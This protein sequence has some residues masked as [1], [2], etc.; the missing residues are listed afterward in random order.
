MS[1]KELEVKELICELCRQFFN[2]GWVTG[3]GG[4]ISIRHE[5]KIFMTPSGVQK[6]R[7]KADELFA[8][9]IKGAIT[10][11]P[12]QKPGGR[13]PKLSDCAPLFLHAYQ[14]RNAGAVLHSHA[15]CCNIVTTLFEGYSEFKISHQEM[16]KGIDGHGYFDQ[17]VVPI[18]ENTA[19]EHELADS[20]GETI[21]KYPK[22]P[23]VLVR[24]HGMYVWGNTWE[25]AKRHGE[26]LHYLFDIAIRMKQ[27]GLDFNSPP[28]PLLAVGNK[29]SLHQN[30]ETENK[31]QDSATDKFQFV[32][33]DIEGTTT[34]ITFVKDVLFPYSS[35]N[36][37]AY[38]TAHWSSPVTVGIVAALQEQVSSDLLDLA[39][40]D[41]PSADLTSVEAVVSYAQWCIQNDRKVTPLKKLQGLIWEAGYQTGALQGQVYPDVAPALSKWCNGGA[42]VAIYSSGSKQA[43]QLLFAHSNS[44]DLREYL[45]AYFDTSIGQ[46]AQSDSY[47]EILLTLGISNARECLFVTDVLA[48]AEAAQDAGMQVV[49]SMRP[50]NA[51]ITAKHSFR[52]ITTFDE[53]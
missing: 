12:C 2:A 38:L 17:L 50:G 40:M 35:L 5:D 14:Q 1:D 31:R 29:R 9:D 21:A 3:T 42:K 24:R 28:R 13:A 18:I 37:H 7:I 27:L 47:K 30:G 43:Q 26:C 48:E 6:E 32:I 53:I 20:L 46:K 10:H 34:P 23:A 22:S 52:T 44:G 33:L 11:T 36:L 49:I 45:S 41:T 51:E 4:S 16:I 8:V 19:W 15:A 25:Q 39:N